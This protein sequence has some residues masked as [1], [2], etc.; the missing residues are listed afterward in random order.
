MSPAHFWFGPL[1][2]QSC[3]KSFGAIVHGRF[4]AAHGLKVTG[5]NPALAK[6]ITF[7][8]G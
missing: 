5:S 7:P 2:V 3:C 6:N 4:D 8:D 1:A